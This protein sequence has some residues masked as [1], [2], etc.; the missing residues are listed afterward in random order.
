[1]TAVTI[2]DPPLEAT[3]EELK[4]R[5]FVART[6]DGAVAPA[7]VLNAGKFWDHKF[8]ELAVAAKAG[9]LGWQTVAIEEGTAQ[10]PAAGGVSVG[11]GYRGGERQPDGRPTLENEFIFVA[12][13]SLTGGISSLID[14][15]TGRELASPADPMGVLEYIVERPRGMSAWV[16]NDTM[17]RS[18]VQ[19]RSLAPHRLGPLV[20]SIVGQGTVAESSF[21]I[22]YTLKACSRQL[23]ID[24]S[25]TWLQRGSAEL[26]VPSLSLKLPLALTGAR[27]TYEIPFGSLTRPQNR[28]EEVPALRW[29]DVSGAGFGGAPAGLAL[30]NDSKYGH[31]LHDSTLRL[32]LVRSSYEPDILPEIGEHSVRVALVPHG[33]PLAPAELM[34]MADAMALPLQAVSTDTHGGNL[35]ASASALSAA[36]ASVVV[37]CIKRCEHED[38]LIIR[39]LETAGAATTATL[40]LDP[41]VFGRAVWVQRCDLLEQAI[42]APVELADNKATLPLCPHD[43]ATV[44]IG[45]AN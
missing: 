32:R 22:A 10:A 43:I 23:E 29:A 38:A 40:E 7:Q 31:S 33:Q 27:A 39:L 14:K 36:P 11:A 45:L 42:D 1:V 17:L 5:G 8:V 30:L 34:R 26:G 24:L 19:L 35:P 3:P 21:T 9:P 4:R 37:T 12:F 18:G 2:W 13:D 20:G 15:A 25:I 44:K 6:A 16:I 41:A 28:G